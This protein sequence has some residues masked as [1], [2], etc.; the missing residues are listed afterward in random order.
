MKYEAKL[1][2]RGQVVI[3]KPLRERLGLAKSDLIQFEENDG[4]VTLT[5]KRDMRKFEEA[6]KKYR[7][8]MRKQFLSEGYKSVDEYMAII[9]GR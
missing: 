5:R 1:G 7:G 2:E 4:A 9:R 3:P 8:S 6:I